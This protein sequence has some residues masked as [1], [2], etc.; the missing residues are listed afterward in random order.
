MS[1][2]ANLR[3][4]RIKRVALVDKG[5]NFD[6]QTGDGAHIMLFK[7]AASKSDSMAAVHV[8]STDWET[9]YEKANL[10][11]EQ[12]NN[13]PDSA[14]AAVWTDSK[15]KHRKLPI[16]DAGHLAAA[17]G[18]IDQADL[19]AD[20]KAEARRRIAAAGDKGSK[21]KEKSMKLKDILKSAIGLMSESDESKRKEGLGQL[22]KAAD[23]LPDDDSDTKVHKADDPMCKCAMCMAKRAPESEITKRMREDFEKRAS[24]LEKR[25]T[26]LAAQLGAEIEKREDDEM[27]T[28]LKSFKRVSVNFDTDVAIFRKM[29]KADPAMYERTMAIMKANEAQLADSMAFAS[30][31]SGMRGTA[32]GNAYAELEAKADALM[33]KSANGLTKEQAMEKVTLDPANRELVKRYNERTQ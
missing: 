33:S 6:K 24:D 19:P 9:D 15:G 7:A 22:A 8:D 21:N 25:N 17:R 23:D 27:R 30:T 14:F 1:K 2:L 16:H 28:I 32:S 10:T 18:R 12:R 5:A 29:K 4:L 20:V 31:G 3:N 13:L 26:E 11:G